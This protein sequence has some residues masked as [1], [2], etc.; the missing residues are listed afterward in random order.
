ML[1]REKNETLA[2]FLEHKVFAD[3]ESVTLTADE[4]E[5]EGFRAF[6]IRYQEA[7]GMEK[8]AVEGLN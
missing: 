2:D 1:R 4:A 7:F 5:A 8:A 6:L 3:A